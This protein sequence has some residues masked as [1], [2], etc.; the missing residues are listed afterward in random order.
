MSNAF[1]DSKILLSKIEPNNTTNCLKNIEINLS[2]ESLN[3][4][5]TKKQNA[6]DSITDQTVLLILNKFIF[7]IFVSF[8]IFLNVFSL[9]LFPYYFKTPLSIDN[10]TNIQ[11]LYKLCYHK[12]VK[13]WYEAMYSENK[14]I[15]KIFFTFFKNKFPM[16]IDYT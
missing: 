11:K 13:S 1:Q 7:Y 2:N 6:Q 8:I 4:N 5:E 3:L 9:F 16:L 12:H 14:L 10:W 15:K